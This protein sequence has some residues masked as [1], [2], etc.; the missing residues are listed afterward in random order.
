MSTFICEALEKIVESLQLVIDKDSALCSSWVSTWARQ[1]EADFDDGLH[2]KWQVSHNKMTV[3]HTMIGHCMSCF[4]LQAVLKNQF[5]CSEDSQSLADTNVI[6]AG[7]DTGPPC[8][9]ARLEISGISPLVK[10]ATLS[11][12]RIVLTKD[13]EGRLSTWD[14]TTGVESP[15]DDSLVSSILGRYFS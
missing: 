2:C 15:L 11:D 1:W 13:A 10:C 7:F 12:R 9:K 5:I 6:T 3:R 8:K 14:V 4:S